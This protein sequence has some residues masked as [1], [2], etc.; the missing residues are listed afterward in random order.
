[1]SFGQMVFA[2]K[3]QSWHD[4]GAVSWIGQGSLIEGEGSVRLTS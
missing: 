1:M 4:I 2:Q 3:W